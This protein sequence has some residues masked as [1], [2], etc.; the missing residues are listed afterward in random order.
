MLILDGNNVL[1]ADKPD[2][3]AGLDD[4]ALIEWLSRSSFVGGGA[5]VVLVFDGLP[6]PLG[7][8][9]KGVEVVFSGGR[10]ADSVIADR[11][12]A[13]STPKR[14]TVV[15]S[16]RAV[17]KQARTRRCTV[18]GSTEFLHRL[19]ASSTQSDSKASGSESSGGQASGGGGKADSEAWLRAFGFEED[20][21]AAAR[22][23]EQAASGPQTLDDEVE[24]LLRQTQLPP[25]LEGPG[26]TPGR[27]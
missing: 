9:A 16:D 12:A 10:T 25:E 19:V 6:R 5:G 3:M 22:D 2:V 17:Q 23:A 1:F 15:S 11:V 21:E 7:V 14:L 24:T 13:S 26:Q 8:S 27:K 20:A 18:W 4:A